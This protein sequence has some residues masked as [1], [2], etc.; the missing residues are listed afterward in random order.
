MRPFG[1]KAAFLESTRLQIFSA[2]A[3]ENNMKVDQKNM[4]DELHLDE[5]SKVS[6]YKRDE[7][8]TDL[9]CC[10]VV[11]GDK[12][13]TFHEEMKCWD[14]LIDHL[15]MLQGMDKGWFAKVSEPAFAATET[16][17]FERL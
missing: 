9:I 12:T 10:D 1:R 4:L 2:G 11:A 6:F 16:V 17:A 5:V 14:A 3:I 8:T 13:L 7:L 15:Q